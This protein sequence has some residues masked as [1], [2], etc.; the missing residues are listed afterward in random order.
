MRPGLKFIK[1]QVR[2][3]GL[4]QNPVVARLC[5]LFSFVYVTV[6]GMKLSTRPQ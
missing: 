1:M 4:V 5:P 3:R 6:Y 2:V